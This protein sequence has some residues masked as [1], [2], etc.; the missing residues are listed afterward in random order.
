MSLKSIIIFSLSLLVV[1]SSPVYAKKKLVRLTTTKPSPNPHGVWTRPKF[2][3]DHQ[4]IL[5]QFGGMDLADT[6]N[7]NLT[8]GTDTVDQGIQ[9]YHEPEKGNTQTELV[10]GTC[11]GTDCTYHKG[12]TDMILEIIIGLK[13]D[14]TLTQRYQITP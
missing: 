4:A 5:V 3:S 7:Y 8:Y 2:R 14:R 10:F 1:A 13:D 11:S 9:G 12:I 6:V